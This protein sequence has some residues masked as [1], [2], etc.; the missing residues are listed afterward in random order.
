[1]S[2]AVDAIEHRIRLATEGLS[3]QTV[4]TKQTHQANEAIEQILA[5]LARSRATGRNTPAALVIRQQQILTRLAREFHVPEESLRARI[6]ELRK[7]GGRT[8]RIDKPAA[9]GSRPAAPI[10]LPVWE[11]EL[12]VLL[13]TSA[14]AMDRLTEQ[15]APEDVGHAL[16]KSIFQQCLELEQAGRTVDLPSLL[17]CYEDERIRSLLVQLDEEA[18]AKSRSELAQRVSD[19]VRNIQKRQREVEVQNHRARL[20]DGNLSQ[21]QEEETLSNLFAQ[22]KS[23]HAGSAPTDG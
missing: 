14:E 1:V 2:G 22:F 18:T 15:I 21:D 12:L 7:R 16:A 23:R 3:M 10:K 11:R 8:S 13:L 4:A 5:T 9:E 6:A 17:L 19:L 20:R